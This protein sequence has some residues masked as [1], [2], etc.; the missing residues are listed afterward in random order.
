[1]ILPSLSTLLFSLAALSTAVSSVSAVECAE[2]SRFGRLEVVPSTVAP[3]QAFDVHA[4]LTCAIYFEIIPTYLDYYVE[5]LTDNNGHEPS[6]Y[7]GRRDYTYNPLSPVDTFTTSLPY[8]YYF[9]GSQ[10]S[11]V[12]D[13]IYPIN[14]TDGST[15]NIVGGTQ[16]LLNVTLSS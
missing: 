6:I 11:V 9:N 8:G 16:A 12:L 5:V 13:M 4:N 7:L 3:G 1:M 14:G 2:A 15:V 10:Y